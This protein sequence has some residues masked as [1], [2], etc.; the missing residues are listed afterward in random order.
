MIAS[1]VRFTPIEHKSVDFAHQSGKRCSQSQNDRLQ[2]LD[3]PKRSV[4]G[5]RYRQILSQLEIFRVDQISPGVM[6]HPE[7]FR[8]FRCMWE[9]ILL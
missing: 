5:F 6:I 2:A 8:Y 7:C 1:E 4:D 9:E 3:S